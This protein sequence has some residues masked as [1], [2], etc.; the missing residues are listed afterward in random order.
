MATF[1]KAHDTSRTLALNTVSVRVRCVQSCGA[2]VRDLFKTQCGT[3]ENIGWLL[4]ASQ[5]NCANCTCRDNGD[6][7]EEEEEKDDSLASHC[8]STRMRLARSLALLRRR[9]RA[10]RAAQQGIEPRTRRDLVGEHASAISDAQSVPLFVGVVD[11]DDLLEDVAN[12]EVQHRRAFCV[13]L[14]RTAPS[15]VFAFGLRDRSL[16]LLGQVIQGRRIIA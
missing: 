4:F 11:V 7:D 3:V 13:G 2:F 16:V 15:Q 9:F 6:E 12:V 10:S 5:L 8:V 14:R 1:R